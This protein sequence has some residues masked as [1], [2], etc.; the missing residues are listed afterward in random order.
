MTAATFD[1][2]R[3]VAG[4]DVASLPPA[5]LAMAESDAEANA[6]RTLGRYGDGATFT[7]TVTDSDVTLEVR[8]VNPSLLAAGLGGP[9]G[10]DT[11]DRSVQVHAE[12]LLCAGAPPACRSVTA[13]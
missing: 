5:E 2:A 7:W 8:V 1:A 10:I 13:P 6:R 9:L 4:Y 11:I 3:H 12:R